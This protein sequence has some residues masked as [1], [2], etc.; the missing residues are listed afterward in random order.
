MNKSL[1]P[2]N[3]IVTKYTTNEPVLKKGTEIYVIDLS[4]LIVGSLFKEMAVDTIEKNEVLHISEACAEHI[5]EAQGN[6]VPLVVDSEPILIQH[7]RWFSNEYYVKVHLKDEPRLSYYIMNP[8]PVYR[9]KW[10]YDD[11]GK[12]TQKTVKTLPL[13]FKSHSSYIGYVWDAEACA[14]CG[15]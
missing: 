6:G 4:G 15:Y 1:K 3:Y 11:N 14:S 2:M 9:D 12:G 10:V 7:N 5:R 13:V 8:I